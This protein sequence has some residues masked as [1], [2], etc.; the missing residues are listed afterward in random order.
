MKYNGVGEKEE[1]KSIGLCVFY[2]NFFE[3]E[4]GV[5][6][7]KVNVLLSVFEAYNL[8]VARGLD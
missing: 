1:Y 5:G 6:V 7:L 3:E 4:E 2:Y 8:F